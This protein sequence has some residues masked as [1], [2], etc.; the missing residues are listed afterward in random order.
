MTTARA[1][2]KRAMQRAG[3]LTKNESPASDEALDAL[4]SLNAMLSSW[5][6]DSMLIYTRVW[7]SFPTIAGISEYT[8]GAGQDFNTIRPLQILSAFIRQDR[9]D[10]P[11]SIISDEI[12]YTFIRD[13]LEQSRPEFLCYDNNYPTGKIRLWAVPDT[14]Y[15]LHLLSE[16]ELSQ[17][18]IDQEVALPPGWE[19]A[20]VDNLA[21][22]LCPEY[23]QQVDQVLYSQAKESKASIS[24]AVNRVR[25]MD[26]QP[27]T[28]LG[29]NN[30]YT[31]W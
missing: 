31:G 1:I 23:G 16:K 4:A 8:I 6:N 24:S 19:L 27:L 7:E 13:K 30:I 15:T 22:R 20:L 10:Y 14:A 26:A 25:D 21:V 29:S 12:Y 17:F 5:S 18:T 28:A 2:I 11:L 9:T 3:V